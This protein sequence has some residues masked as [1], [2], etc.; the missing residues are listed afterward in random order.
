[1][2]GS[3]LGGFIFICVPGTNQLI[4]V[5]ISQN[6]LGSCCTWSPEARYQGD[7]R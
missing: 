2:P 3:A 5:C 1:M 6:G 7:R 4:T